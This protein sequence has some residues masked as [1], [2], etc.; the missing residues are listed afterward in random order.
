M[1]LYHGVG[2]YIFSSN[3]SAGRKFASN[4][5]GSDLWGRV[6]WYSDIISNMICLTLVTRWNVFLECDC[7]ALNCTG[8]C[9]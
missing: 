8:P 7:Y 2:A 3:I 9:I 1:N 6:S 5:E 4:L